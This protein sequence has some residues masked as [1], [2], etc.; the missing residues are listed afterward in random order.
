[1]SEHICLKKINIIQNTD[2]LL[3]RVLTQNQSNP[4]GLDTK[5]VKKTQKFLL[6]IPK[7]WE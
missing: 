2:S 6:K 1:M 3:Y 7:T 4:I 5:E